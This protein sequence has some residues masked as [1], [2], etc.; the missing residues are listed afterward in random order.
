[1]KLCAFCPA[2]TVKRGGEHIWDDWLNRALPTTKFRVK[3]RLSSA[4]PFREY[5]AAILK[6]KLP[7]VCEKCNHTWM[8][9]LTGRVKEHFHDAI[10]NDDPLYISVRDPALL[11][12]FT[13]L[14]AIVA[15]H[16]IKKENPFFTRA[17]REQ[18]RVSLA[19]P[20]EVQIWIA[21]YQGAQ[22]YSGRCSNA[23]LTP[24][25]PSPLYGIEF[26]SFTYVVGHLVLQ[27][28][29][30][31]WKYVHRRSAT[32]PVLSPHDQWSPATIQVWPSNGSAVSW[33]PSKYLG[34]N[35]IEAFINRFALPIRM[36]IA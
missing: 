6:E 27:L 3:Q 34:D 32:L 10:V 26:Y 4:D 12:A 2:E 29:A 22:R 18:F 31:R 28:H 7:A 24:N 17:V 5:E 33:P 13:F 30:P 23:I 1:M 16:A 36:R 9:D 14:K 19:I 20:P 8:S 35:I 11:A 25:E 15:D 21:A